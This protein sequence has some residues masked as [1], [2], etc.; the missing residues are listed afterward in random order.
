[1]IAV[2]GGAGYTGGFLVR[3]LAQGDGPVRCLVRPSSDRRELE[4][5]GVEVV[6]AD[7]ESPAQVRAGLAG[8]RTILHVAHI[9]FAGTVVAQAPSTTEQ[10]VCVSSQ[11]AVSRVP[12]PSVDRA[13]AGERAAACGPVPWT[14]LRPTMIYGPGDDRNLSRL[15]AQLRRCRWVPVCGSGRALQQPVWVEDVVSAILGA[16]GNPRAIGRVYALGGAE[17]LP[18]DELLDC[19]GA[20][21]GVRP[22]KVHLPAGVCVAAVR[23][24]GALGAR[25]GLEPEQLWRLQEDK[26]CSFEAARADLGYDPLTLAQG[27]ARLYGHG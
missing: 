12:S 26:A 5:L 16:C 25:P 27:L 17:P 6:L 20:A 1:M 19:V 22:V 18:L 15:A 2:T 7:L 11:R 3:R 21:V 4:R 8:A 13:Q 9:R 10:V 24:L 23:L 14:I